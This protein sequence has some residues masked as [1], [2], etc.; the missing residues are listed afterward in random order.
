MRLAAAAL[1]SAAA[2]LWHGADT[3]N[4]AVVTGNE[5]TT[6]EDV[7]V[8]QTD[9]RAIVIPFDDVE[10]A[11]ANPTLY[12][13]KKNSPNYIDLNGTWKFYWV[14]KPA[15]KPDVEGVTSIPDNYFDITVPSSWQTNMKYAGWKG[16]EIDWPIYNNQDYPWEASGNGIPKQAR[17]NGSAAPAEY[18]P[19]GTYMR[20]VNINAADIGKQRF[21]ITFLGVES[22]YYLYVNGRAVGYDEDSFTTGEFDITDYVRAGE[23]L[24]TVQV[25]HYTTGSYLENQDMIAYAGIHRDVFITKQPKVSIFDYNVETIFKDHDYTSAELDLTVDVSNTADTAATRKVRA[26][27]YDNKGNAVS[28]VNG[29]EQNVTAAKGETAKAEFSV[30]VK[31][32][33][34]WSAELPNLYT[35]VLELCDGNGNTLQTVGKRIGFRE[36]YMEGKGNN[37]EM[38]INGQNIEFYGVCRGEADP[39][40]G[41]HVPYETIVKDV[42]NAK[43]LNINSIRT[44]HFPPDPNLIELAD[45][46]G[47]Y[48]MD[49]VNVESHN[50]RTL[51]IPAN[52]QYETETGRIFPGNDKRYKNAMVDR[53]T[54]LVMRDKNNASVLIYSLGNEAGSDASDRLAPDPQEGNFNRMIDVIKE[55]DS[56]KLIHYQGWVANQ[57]VDMEGA[58][59]PAHNKLN[60]GAKPFIMME[61]QHSMGNTGGD[62]AVYTDK[63]EADAR[64]QGG[65]LWDYVDQS[66]YTPKEGKSGSNLT[67]EDLFFGFDHSWKANSD[68]YNFCVNGFIFPDRTWSPQAYEIKYGYQDLKFSQTEEQ[69]AEKKITIRNFN[70]FKNA[71]YYDIK[72]SVLENGK[73]LSS[74]IFTDEEVNLA[75]PTGRIAGASTKEVTAPYTI[76]NPKAGAEYLLLIEYKLKNNEV[77]AKKGYVQGSEQ[78]TIDVKGTDKLLALKD[79]PNV[80]TVDNANEV[81]ITG[82]TKEGKEFKVVVDKKTG[83]MKTYQAD[84][85]DLITKAPV[86]S[87][88]RAEP[89][90]NA[91]VNGTGWAKGNGEAYDAWCDQGENMKDVSVTVKSVVP[92]MTTVS[93]NAKLRNDSGYATSYSVYGNGT[94]VVT[95]KLTPSASAPDQLGEYGMWMQAPKEF[96]NLTWYGRG[97]AETY[98]N[99]KAGNMIKVWGEEEKTT[100]EEQF[101]PYL[102]IQEAGNKTD[103]RWI[104][105]RDDTG[106]GLLAGMTYGEGYTG[107]ALE[108]VALHYTAKE[109]STR[110]SGHWYPYQAEAT[111]DINL[112]LLTHQKGV[113][114]VTW[115]TEPVSA[116]IRKSDT[117]LLNYSYTLM[118]LFADSDA[119]EKSREILEEAPEIPAITGIALDMNGGR[120]IVSGFTA[121]KTEYTIE[122]PT[123]Y[124]GLPAVSA[125]GPS[126]LTYTYVQATEE[127][128]TATLTATYTPEGAAPIPTVY[129]VHFV[130]SSS[131]G[132]VQLSSLVTVPATMVQKVPLIHPAD[133]GKLLYAFSG[134]NRTYQDKNQNGKTLTLGPAASQTT[135]EY[136]FAGNAE[137]IMDIDIS[138]QK[139]KSFSAMGGIDW[140]MKANNATSSIKFE[141]WAHKN[142][143]MLTAEYYGNED[144]MNPTNNGNGTADWTATGW[145]KLQGSETAIKGN[146]ADPKEKFENVSLTYQE[147]GEEKFYEAIRLVMNA[148][149]KDSHDQGVWG[150]PRILCDNVEKPGSGF[151]EPGEDKEEILINGI[152]LKGFSADTREYSVKISSGAKIPQVT[153]NVRKAG[154]TVLARISKVTVPG[155]VTVSYDNGTAKTFTIHFTRDAAIEGTA[156]Y[157]S[158]VVKIPS[159]TG[160]DFV[161]D[162]NLLYA[163]SEKGAIYKDKDSTGAKLQLKDG[164][165]VKTYDHG[166]AGAA[167]QVIDVDISSR[168]AGT[169]QADAGVSTAGGAAVKFEVW[170]HKSVG[171]LDYS[172]TKLTAGGKNQ[173]DFAK[174]GW[175]KLD[176][177]EALLAEDG[178][179]HFHTDL[180][181]LQDTETKNY[182]AIRL[183]MRSE[184]DGQG[185]WGDPVVEFIG[186]SEPLMLVPVLNNANEE[187]DGVS[188]PV[189]LSGIDTSQDRMF[190]ALL[191]AYD[192]NNRMAGCAVKT[193]NAKDTGGNIDETMKVGYDVAAVGNTTVKFM[194]WDEA[195][196]YAPIYGVF[197]RNNKN[198]FDYGKL[199]YVSGIAESAAAGLAIDAAEDAVTVTGTGFAP[200]SSLTLRASYE[201]EAEDDHIAQVTADSRGNF[202]YTY[203]SNY[204]LEADSYLDVIVGGNGL[205]TSV[206]ATTRTAEGQ[207]R[208]S[209]KNV[210][211]RAVYNDRTIDLSKAEGLFQIDEHAGAAKYSV[212]SGGTGEAVMGTDNQTLTVSKNG[213]IRIGLVTAQNGN[214]ASGKR[215]IAVLT[216]NNNSNRSVLTEAIALAKE[217]KPSDYGADSYALLLA[218]VADAEKAAANPNA[219]QNG[220]DSQTLTLLQAVYTLAPAGSENPADLK[221]L[222]VIVKLAE[223]KDESKYTAESWTAVAAALAAA[224][225]LSADSSAEVIKTAAGNLLTALNDLE[226][227]TEVT[228]IQDFNAGTAAPAGWKILQNA[229]NQMAVQAVSGAPAGYPAEVTGNALRAYGSGSGPRG[230]RVAYSESKVPQTATFEF[231]FYIKTAPSNQPNLLYLE[232]GDAVSFVN[233]NDTVANTDKSFF[234]L[235]DGKK[236][237]VLQYYDYNAKAWVDIPGGSGKWLHAIVTADFAANTVSFQI[238]NGSKTIAE[239]A[240]ENAMAF[241]DTVTTFNRIT[242]G[243]QRNKG[244]TNCDI[245]LDNFKMSGTFESEGIVVKGLN[246]EKSSI[247][248]GTGTSLDHVKAALAEIGFYG[249]V[250]SGS[251]APKMENSAEAWTIEGYEANTAGTYQATAAFELPEGFVWAD[252]VEKTVKVSV[253]VIARAD[254][255]ALNTAIARAKDRKESDYTASSW[256]ELQKAL[257]K[258]EELSAKE[259]ATQEEVNAAT[260]ALRNAI[261]GLKEADKTG[262]R[263]AIARAEG[264]NEADYTAESWAAMQTAL[265]AARETA[266]NAD[267]TQSQI[268]EATFA[269]SDALRKLEA[270]KPVNKNALNVVIER[271]NERNEAD[272]KAESWAAMQTALAAAQELAARED[273]TQEEVN[274]ATA[275][276][277]EAIAELVR[278]DGT[279]DPTDKKGLN[280][281][282]TRANERNEE[283]YTAESWTAMQAVLAEA[284]TIAAKTDATQTEVD[285]ATFQLSDALRNLKEVTAVNK[286]ALNVVIDRAKNKN[287]ADYTASSW[288]AM[289]QKLKEAEDLAVKADATQEEVNAAAEALREAIANLVRVDKTGL[290]EAIA[291]AAARNEAD[292][293]AESWAVMKKALQDA[294]DVAANADAVQVE[295][296]EATR[297][298]SEAIRNL[299]EKEKMVEP[300]KGSL[301]ETVAEAEGKKQSDYTPESWAQF[302]QVLAQVKAILNKE[303]ATQEEIDKAKAALQEAI[304]NLKLK[305]QTGQTVKV[306]AAGSVFNDGI[307]QYKITKSNAKNGTAAVAGLLNKKRSKI[308]IPAT[309]KKDGYTFKV[310]EILKGVFQ[311]NRKIT[312]VQIGS[313]VK[314]IGAKSFYNCKKLNRITFKNKNAVKIGS[315]AFSGIKKKCKVTVP[316]KMTKKNFAKLKKG[317]KSAG[318][319]IV[320]KKK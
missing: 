121:D 6:P 56:E 168:K 175:V 212:V 247:T 77:Y 241:A 103:V 304:K 205:E 197:T 98:W 319:K 308:T 297:A 251:I 254:K 306:P 25:Y 40:G 270:V 187:D 188:V 62:F 227:E 174:E 178:L 202:S 235:I 55:L 253:I 66:A 309:V 128:K 272:Y 243:C 115:A 139:A 296:D 293:T 237:G 223:S 8:G 303:G 145:V 53:M 100:V 177:S 16:D 19:V 242:I 265:A 233:E 9:A 190:H 257:Q 215:V 85:R 87:F 290:N 142:V 83:L 143:S 126:S 89:D 58:M 217:K 268:D 96:E 317:M 276:L 134:Y 194:L 37:S 255:E 35:L 116:V 239:V 79:M 146:A 185:V 267:A 97:P 120:K 169:F 26:Y 129:K 222:N 261:A 240:P 198:G 48:I 280:A 314:K 301:A 52:A 311:K 170:A 68:D 147:D 111:E 15:D 72:W 225:E 99:R 250:A 122:L 54:S 131:G 3:A 105:L 204:D 27:L 259:D 124:E 252:G 159:L 42:Q 36:F 150:N 44:S 59:Y 172:N 17:G 10:G 275:A 206:K 82:T 176:E 316:K 318:K 118:P 91:A 43:Q 302:E 279:K 156:A 180:T 69:K 5:W 102:R 158:D 132:E 74:G 291:R 246:A 244:T 179:Y 213:T 184:G 41:H 208:I 214:Y 201:K 125:I 84:G 63:F 171:L 133:S 160:P 73:E 101:V 117:E 203:T 93:V 1:L 95:A 305:Q 299:K 70:R 108:A 238:Q 287:E 61:Y 256:A 183:V 230:G 104:A 123:G 13:G 271:A 218:A 167:Q 154:G 92:Q 64:F 94:V 162:G 320:Y 207:G 51:A 109:L 47:L 24:I 148:D 263:E 278:T 173:T 221:L 110:Q 29:I 200:N 295:I 21:I 28:S 18:N 60:P 219:L 57:R 164:E 4:A 34:L 269:L 236:N 224:K 313:N 151:E 49:E 67:K 226:I 232:Q 135:Y 32:P 210:P 119:M 163:Y 7:R 181:Y 249:K 284:Q 153:A 245:W 258:A 189:L 11:K 130:E 191:A 277:R 71:N 23:N 22:G 166:F 228:V 65:F 2:F 113:G 282:I 161:Q 114:N 46:Y 298:L 152:P 281:A 248:V 107:N 216:V 286:N 81:T 264:R 14:S 310:T 33:K 211:G 283:D 312:Q 90:Q 75:P 30:K 144:Y 199:P 78:F 196:P 292:Y 209:V 165:S 137:Q 294:E 285:E 76:A 234:A 80:A 289:Q 229:N 138:G 20:T 220:L 266:A 157:L 149:G 192:E 288:A 140:D 315:K 182:E 39:A 86:G 136:G 45:E 307:L 260:T 155:D 38:R 106:A 112:R 273:A 193:Y 300:E 274:A 141:V 195:D 231:D 186:D 127:E 88:F 50:A 262:L 12:L 31:N